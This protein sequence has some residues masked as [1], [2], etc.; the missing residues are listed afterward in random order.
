[1][2]AGHHLGAYHLP[3][4]QADQHSIAWLL[5]QQLAELLVAAINFGL[6]VGRGE[7]S[8]KHYMGSL[9]L[10]VEDL[11]WKGD[12]EENSYTLGRELPNFKTIFANLVLTTGK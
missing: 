9:D 7:A 5:C 8:E 11:Q 1:M 6:P 2:H 12:R 3:L 4:H 10:G